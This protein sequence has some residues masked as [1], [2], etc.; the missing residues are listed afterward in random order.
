M[1]SSCEIYRVVELQTIAGTYVQYLGITGS[2]GSKQELQA[3]SGNY[4]Q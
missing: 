1:G 3:P 4:G 2:M